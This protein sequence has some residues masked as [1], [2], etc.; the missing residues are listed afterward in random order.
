LDWLCRQSVVF[1]WLL[2]WLSLQQWFPSVGKAFAKFGPYAF[3]KHKEENASKTGDL[4]LRDVMHLVHAKPLNTDRTHKWTKEHR[5]ERTLLPLSPSPKEIL[6]S[7]L[8]NKT[9][10]VPQ[11]RETLL[12]TARTVQEKRKVY[13]TLIKEGKLGTQALLMNLV[14]MLE[15][16]IDR[17]FVAKTVLAANPEKLIPTQFLQA[18]TRAPSLGNEVEALMLKSLTKFTRLPGRTILVVDCSGSMGNY[19]DETNYH[20]RHGSP[21]VEPVRFQRQDVANLLAAMAKEMCDD[22]SIYLTAGNDNRGVHATAALKST[23]RGFTL[24]DQIRRES[25]HLGGGGIFTRQALEYIRTQ[26]TGIPERII[27]ISDSQDCDKRN[28]IP[29][30]FGKYNYIVDVS[31]HKNGIN[32]KGVWTQEI[33]G[34]SPYFLEY[35]AQSELLQ[36]ELF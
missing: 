8:S 9:L 2:R 16:G 12:S 10:P 4:S 28:P 1:S 14:K 22:V 25:V 21:T 6:Y 3:G 18:Y 13:E 31:S 29:K 30:P 27:V 24:N 15:L 32:Y 11:T 17:E 26:E 33:S 19:I 5:V 20:K 34:W 35:I 7:Q 36:S 23:A